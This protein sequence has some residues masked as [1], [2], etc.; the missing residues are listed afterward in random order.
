MARNFLEHLFYTTV[1]VVA[2]EWLVKEKKWVETAEEQAETTGKQIETE[3]SDMKTIRTKEK[4]LQLIGNEEK[5]IHCVFRYSLRI[6]SECGKIRTRNNSV[7][8]HF[9]RSDTQVKKNKIEL[10]I[11]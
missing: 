1:P 6:Q 11:K 10:N 4:Q 7:F 3:K 8:G 5:P 9:S 2:S